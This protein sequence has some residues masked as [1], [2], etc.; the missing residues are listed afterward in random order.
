MTEFLIA[1]ACLA[2][3][4]QGAQC[5]SLSGAP[6]AH[7]DD[8][9]DLGGLDAPARPLGELLEPLYGFRSL[10]SFKA[11]FQ[12]RDVPLYLVFR[13]EAA[14]PRIGLALTEA[15][16]PGTPLGEGRA[17]RRTGPARRVGRARRPSRQ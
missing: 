17:R 16:L 1:S 12:P 7:S 15:Y 2:F 11:K 10:E 4:E 5:V 9:A 8:V 13:D 6:L 3:Q 14:L